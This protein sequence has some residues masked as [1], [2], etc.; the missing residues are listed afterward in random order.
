[1]WAWMAKVLVDGR[2]R[3]RSLHRRHLLVG[4]EAG[5]VDR[6]LNSSLRHHL[7]RRL[8]A[9]IRNHVLIVHGLRLLAGRHTLG[10]VRVATLDRMLLDVMLIDALRMVRM[11]RLDSSA[12]VGNVARW[13]AHV[14]RAL[15]LAHHALAWHLLL[16]DLMLEVHLL[17]LL[18]SHA[19]MMMSLLLLLLDVVR[20][21]R[22]YLRACV[23]VGHVVRVVALMLLLDHDRTLVGIR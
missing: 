10:L 5:Y 23:H 4:H 16:M 2:N 13:M 17:L 7:D 8:I 21:R 20:T 1:M 15:R 18:R 22:M 11:R 3:R 14:M 6:L 12:G 9:R 19:R